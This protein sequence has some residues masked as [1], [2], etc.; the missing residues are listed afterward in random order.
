MKNCL[1]CGHDVF[2]HIYNHR[3]IKCAN[4]SF[5]TTEFWRSGADIHE[6]YTEKYF[7]GE[8]Y[9][10]YL[11]EKPALQANFRTRL[12]DIFQIFDKEAIT[13]VLEIGC[14]YGFFAEVLTQH[15][16]GS[17][18]VGIDIVEPAIRYGRE[19]LQQN[20]FC[21]DY[22]QFVSTETYSDIFLWDVIEHL[23]QPDEFL[24]KAAMELRAGG[25]LYLTTGDISALF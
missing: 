12:R 25:R 20:L 11:R 1:V 21:G 6:I 23:K 24:K 2:E 5:V 16:P 22:L 18:Y 15:V 8:E 19:T 10:D 7:Q 4:C 17:K 13:S 3:L 9:I 14:A